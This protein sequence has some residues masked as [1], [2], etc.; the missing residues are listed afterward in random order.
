MN[1]TLLRSWRGKGFLFRKT[2]FPIFQ[3]QLFPVRSERKSRQ[4]FD[5]IHKLP[6]G[7]ISRIW[8]PAGVTEGGRDLQ[9]PHVS[10]YPYSRGD[11]V[12]RNAGLPA[13]HTKR[14]PGFKKRT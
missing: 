8:P 7:K 11:A 5:L 10:L 13:R 12:I 9:E 14:G 4:E 1:A 6:A 3:H 2:Y